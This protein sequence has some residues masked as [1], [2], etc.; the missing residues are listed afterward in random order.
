MSYSSGIAASRIKGAEALFPQ[1]TAANHYRERILPNEPSPKIGHSTG[2]TVSLA[3]ERQI[4]APFARTEFCQTNPV[5]KSDTA[6]HRW[7]HRAIALF[8]A[9]YSLTMTLQA[10]THSLTLRQAV[11]LVNND[12]LDA[13]DLHAELLQ[14]RLHHAVGLREQTAEHVQRHNL[15][16]VVPLRHFLRAGHEPGLAELDGA[17]KVMIDDLL[18][19]TAALKMAR[20]SAS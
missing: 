16:V 11:E 14:Q 13:R 7:R 18:W 8:A 9:T 6:S 1:T 12:L 5:P 19:W 15:R 4:L 3:A 17:A 2:L 20:G 10:E